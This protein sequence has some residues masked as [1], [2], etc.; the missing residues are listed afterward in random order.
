MNEYFFINDN[1]KICIMKDKSAPGKFFE[2][3]ACFSVEHLQDIQKGTE[4]NI[5]YFAEDSELLT[6]LNNVK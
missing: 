6:Y 3:R 2:V 4:R 5:L 1:G